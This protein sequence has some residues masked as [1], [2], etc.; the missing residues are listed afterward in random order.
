MIGMAVKAAAIGAAGVYGFR[1][2]E[3]ME[4]SGI[5]AVGEKIATAV[6]DFADGASQKAEKSTFI[7]NITDTIKSTK[8]G[9]KILGGAT[10]AASAGVK[11]VAAG[12][13]DFFKAMSDAKQASDEGKGTFLSN[14]LKNIGKEAA[15]LGAKAAAGLTG[16]VVSGARFVVEH[17]DKAAEATPVRENDEPSRTA[18]T[19]MEM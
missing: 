10:K 16:A 15:G 8:I 17:A 7:K 12:A 11:G 5:K 1:K 18:D 9:E 13:K 4:P 3:G 14:T 6:T 19:Q 2:L